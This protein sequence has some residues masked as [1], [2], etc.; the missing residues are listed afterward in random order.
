MRNLFGFSTT[1]STGGDFL[2]IIKYDARA[3]RIFRMDRAEIG[4]GFENKA[5]DIT[6]NFKA[7]F[8]LESVET[9]WIDFTPGSAPDFNLVPL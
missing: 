5:V 6:A 1:P 4:N 2:P 7:M 3:G 9:G 8:D